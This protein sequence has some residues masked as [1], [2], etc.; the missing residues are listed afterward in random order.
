MTTLRA[1]A[2]RVSNL[3]LR[4]RRDARL[5]EEVQAHLDLLADEHV[6]RGMAPEDAR[7][8]ARKAF[9]GVDQLKALY[10]DQ[11][12]LPFVDALWQDVRIGV[13]MLIRDCQFTAV[14]AL[15]LA[16]GMGATTAMFTIVNG[17]N[18]R[19]LPFDEPDEVVALS[20]TDIRGRRQGVC[21]HYLDWRRA[22]A[23]CGEWP[24]TQRP[25]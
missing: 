3:L 15:A 8:A 13:R 24:R 2:S 16:L 10:R 19:D 4:R 11:R 21:I 5:D 20:T 17:M 22:C 9:G 18:L 25:Q 23:R 14:A 6:A 7:L 1:L 12:G